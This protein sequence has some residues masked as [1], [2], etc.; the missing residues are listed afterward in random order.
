LADEVARKVKV[1]VNRDGFAV[2]NQYI[3][4]LFLSENPGAVVLD[5]EFLKVYIANEID[6]LI[7]KEKDDPELC[8]YARVLSKSGKSGEYILEIFEKKWE[9]TR[10]E[11]INLV[12]ESEIYKEFEEAW[13]DESPV[14]RLYR[15]LEKT[16]ESIV[17]KRTE[18]CASYDQVLVYKWFYSS[19]NP[20]NKKSKLIISGF[21]DIN[22][23]TFKA[24]IKLF[25]IFEDVDFYIWDKINDRS[26]EFLPSIYK[27][28]KSQNF[29]EENLSSQTF[30]KLEDLFSGTQSVSMRAVVSDDPITDIQST[31]VQIKKKILYEGVLPQD[32]G[33]VTPDMASAGLMADS[34]E[35]MS[36]PYRFKNDIPLSKSK[37]VSI[38]VLPLK[39]VIRGCEVQDFIA[40][41]EAGFA[42]DT[43]LA[44]E[45]V[46][47]YF[48]RLGILYDDRKT[49]IKQKKFEWLGWIDEEYKR[50]N[51]L[52]NEEEH[53][54]AVRELEDLSKLKLLMEKIFEV[55][56]EIEHTP[57][58]KSSW[59]SEKVKSWIENNVL[60]FEVLKKYP[61]S[62]AVE[63]ETNAILCFIEL[64][65]KTEESL[66]KLLEREKDKTIKMEKFYYILSNLIQ[67]KTF[68]SSQRYSNTVEI[69][70]LLDSRFVNKKIKYFVNFSESSY[71]SIGINP[72]LIYLSCGGYPF[73]MV[74]E[75][76]ARRNLLISLAFSQNVVISYPKASV[77]GEPILPSIYLKEIMEMSKIKYESEN[78]KNIVPDSPDEIF[79]RE[80][81]CIYC[82]A[83]DVKYSGEDAKLKEMI[84]QS[85]Y[86]RERAAL[87][88]WTLKEPTKVDNFSHTKLSAYIDC[89][90]KY[91]LKYSM[92]LKGDKE[93]DL[94]NEGL[95]KHKV[96]YDIF[97]TYPS[98]N[99]LS[100]A[101]SNDKNFSQ[102][103]YQ[104][105]Q[106]RWIDQ[107]KEGLYQYEIVRKQESQRIA[108]DLFSVVEYISDGYV[109]LDKKNKKIRFA[110][111]DALEKPFE[112]S[113]VHNNDTIKINTRID[114]IDMV[115]EN[116][117]YK[118]SKTDTFLEKK[119]GAIGI[120]DYKNSEHFQSEQLFLYYKILNSLNY[121]EGED[122][123]LIFLVTKEDKSNK[124]LVI[125]I[126]NN[127]VYMKKSGKS[128]EY[129]SFNFS[130]FDTW[131]N[132]VIGDIKSSYFVPLAVAEPKRK[133]F[134]VQM[135]EKYENSSS[136][137]SVYPCIGYE[138]SGCEYL[139]LCS[140]LGYHEGF[141]L[142]AR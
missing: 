73:Y 93:F 18:G 133:K 55:L 109:R 101:L 87:K 34:L 120:I 59:Y 116:Y 21:F 8:R 141:S 46:E 58:V 28:L 79:S 123:Y 13:Q 54:R 85:E 92:L 61:D 140:L 78:R 11:D 15:K 107:F 49:A 64:L 104:I 9:I 86:I 52:D 142:K 24:M 3:T 50:L 83:N 31:A 115:D 68:R 6:E 62:Q 23:I 110:K 124:S 71:P 134:L 22:P 65:D 111:V 7:E 99:D 48:K 81:A 126:Q 77:T 98:R 43:E 75:K 113:I 106:N 45:D 112:T 82:V 20:T 70:D 97:N 66:E 40:M 137:E 26:F 29:V 119:E 56:D 32:I 39:T 80:D 90:F 132:E 139:K 102:W 130:E 131:L 114:R 84:R 30:M 38:L 53:E 33:V 95:L 2:I 10:T 4:E 60:G 94:F 57:K 117:E 14:G 47:K 135:K 108:Q 51:L 69:M 89:P 67:T 100:D 122:V 138:Y 25:D 88:L 63:T 12:N 105:V 19:Y 5:R 127:E 96:L 35:K 118:P 16:L 121:T 17:A 72:L 129:V 36:V 136:S 74:Q 103:I 125:K 27:F 41:I 76:Q 42:G 1:T 91:F 37:S 44:M 128:T